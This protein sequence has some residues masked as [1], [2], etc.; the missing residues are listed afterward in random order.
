MLTVQEVGR[1]A[2]ANLVRLRTPDG[3]G[4]FQLHLDAAGQP[5][6]CRW[7][8]LIDEVTPADADEWAVWIDPKEG[9][10]GW[11]QFETKDGKLYDRVWSPG[12]GRVA[13]RELTEVI[14]G[15]QGIRT[16][17]GIAMLYA[18]PSGAAA[19]APAVEYLLVTAIDAGGQAWVEIR[20]GL[21]IN[22]ATLS[23]A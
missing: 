7:F 4:Y 2:S 3:R 9:L 17:H 11:P 14:E 1:I 19:P 6:E 22:P 12:E 21:D 20:A 8:G 15:L 23:L 13:P 18:A 10:I 16:Q 5:D